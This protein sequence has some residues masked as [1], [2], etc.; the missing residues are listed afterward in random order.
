MGAEE[1]IQGIRMGFE[2]LN[3]FKFFRVLQSIPKSILER[4]V[5]VARVIA[6]WQNVRD[7]LLRHVTALTHLE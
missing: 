7:L 1:F 5:P 3:F 2:S 6:T 4:F